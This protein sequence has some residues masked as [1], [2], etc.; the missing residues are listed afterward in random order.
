MPSQQTIDLV[1]A[2]V[3]ALRAHGEAITTHFYQSMFRDF[4]A[5]KAFFNQAHQANGSQPRALAGAVLA[6]AAH[7]DRLEEIA[8]A[9]PAIIQKHVSLGIAP[10]HY[11]IVGQCLLRAIREVLGEAATDDILAAWAEAYGELAALLIAAEE[12]VYA[13][14][15]AQPGGWRGTRR[16]VVARRVRESDEILSLH[17]RPEDGG[18]LPA[19]LPGQ[20][21]ALVLDIGGATLRR[22]YSLSAAPGGD[23]LRISVK[24]QAGGVASNWLHDQAVE[25]TVLAVTP[26]AGEFTLA[27]GSRPLLF[28][29]AGVGITPALAML[30]AAAPAGRRIGF[31]HAARTPAVAAFRARIEAI[32][33]AHAGVTP[34]FRY[35]ATA[36]DAPEH[37]RIDAAALAGLLPA[38]GAVDVYLL[39]PAPFMREMLGL[40]DTL[41]VARERVRVEFFG[42]KEALAG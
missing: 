6:Y 23:G 40:L 21:I 19:W 16:F 22:N 36:A 31:V 8:P 20:Y 11:P 5:V 10:E 7:I 35:S 4:P 37:G 2:T 17:L 13:D 33:A 27:E 15:A 24:R 25:G 32:A 29:T 34:R 41:G 3:P 42:P 26:P 28:I 1:K 12:K 9:L 38:D 39:G 14:T 18:A 30:E